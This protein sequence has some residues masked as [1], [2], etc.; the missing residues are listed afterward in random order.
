MAFSY[1]FPH[2]FAMRNYL[3]TISHE[4]DGQFGVQRMPKDYRVPA[5]SEPAA[6]RRGLSQYKREVTRGK[7]NIH[8]RVRIDPLGVV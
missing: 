3:I 4:R 8:Y 1:F 6:A 2:F 7:K 5:S